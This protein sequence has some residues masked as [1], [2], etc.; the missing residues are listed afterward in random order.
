MISPLKPDVSLVTQTRTELLE[1]LKTTLGD[2]TMKNYL[3]FSRVIKNSLSFRMTASEYMEWTFAAECCAKLTREADDGDLIPEPKPANTNDLIKSKQIEYMEF[4]AR[5]YNCLQRAGY[6]TIGDILQADAV[7]FRRIRNFGEK[8][9][10][11][12]IYKIHAIGGQMSWEVEQNDDKAT[13]S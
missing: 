9:A 7:S 11:E 4:Y 1:L 5:T 3:P 8:S 12:V 6:R 2:K 10:N 13:N